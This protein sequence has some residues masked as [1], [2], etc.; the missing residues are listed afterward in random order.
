MHPDDLIYVAGHRGLVGSAIVRRLQAA[1]YRNLLLRTH[2]DLDLTDMPATYDFLAARRP[3]VVFLCAARVGGIGANS[4]APTD[5]LLDNAR[6]SM[7]VIDGA[8]RAGTR[9]LINLG[10]SC[11]YPRDA[12][13]PIAESALMTGPLEAT[14][15]A[16]ALAKIAALKL[17]LAEN[18]RYGTDFYSLMP[19]NLYGTGDNYDLCSSHVLPALIA[20]FHDAKSGERDVVTLWGDGT[21][22]RE[23]LHADDLAAAA[24]WLAE[25]CSARD[26][27]GWINVGS[28]KELTIAALAELVRDVVY[29]DAPATTPRPRIAWDTTRPNGTPRKLLDSTRIR[30]L[31]WSPT[32][33]LRDGVTA[34]YGDYREQAD[35]NT[36]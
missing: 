3:D 23:F 33:S 28:G 20:R 21:P 25:R 12:A 13:Q 2:A 22:L 10:S 32:I 1:G 4:D 31:G 36:F 35:T 30:A 29:A 16:Y 27:G 24:V 14:N 7:N 26:V 11:I 15:E 5:F 17:C 9:R 18:A 34:A 8:R 6:I 19:T